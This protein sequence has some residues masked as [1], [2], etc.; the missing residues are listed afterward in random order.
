MCLSI[1]RSTLA[2]YKKSTINCQL[3]TK[4]T[5]I[6]T[7]IHTNIHTYL[8]TYIRTYIHTYIYRFTIFSYLK[9]CSSY[10]FLLKCITMYKVPFKSTA[11]N[12]F[13]ILLPRNCVHEKAPGTARLSP[14]S[15]LYM[16]IFSSVFIFKADL[17]KSTYFFLF[18]TTR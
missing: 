9:F 16:Y 8:H 10:S 15:I 2:P 3:C 17:Y 7:Y 12:K 1:F 13:D 5:Y 6:H 11:L 14:E 4:H 18:L